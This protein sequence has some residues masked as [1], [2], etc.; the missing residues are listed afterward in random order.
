MEFGTGPET[1]AGATR[2]MVLATRDVRLAA[3]LG[4][5]AR[6][7]ALDV[8]APDGATGSPMVAIVDA[9]IVDAT[10]VDVAIVDL[11]QADGLETVRAW[12]RR[13]P[14]A[15][16]AGYL[17]APD[18]D[19][20]VAAQRA[21]CDVVT[22]R[23]ALVPL[24]RERLNE[25]GPG[26]PRRFPLF[27]A[28]DVAGRLGIVYRCDDTPVGPITVV[29]AAGRLCAVADRCPHAGAVLSS[30]SVDGAVLTCPGHGSQFDVTTGE[31]VRGPADDAVSS[32]QLVEERGQVFLVLP[33]LS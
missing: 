3:R 10:I 6:H 23:G 9:A 32:F 4:E 27:E 11:D 16:L 31:R 13:W 17:S 14:E 5:L 26:R 2:A 7:A 22:N 24:L 12:R 33:I 25:I 20:W 19:R 8:V 15:L 28:A 29:R 30:G 21:G 1:A 18:R